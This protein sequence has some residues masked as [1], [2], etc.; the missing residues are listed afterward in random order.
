MKQQ[1]KKCCWTLWISVS[2]CIAVFRSGRRQPAIKAVP[3]LHRVAARLATAPRSPSHH[4]VNT[5]VEVVFSPGGGEDVACD[6]S[7]TFRSDQSTWRL[8]GCCVRCCVW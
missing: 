7:T 4:Q 6:S 3:Q 1:D 2:H 5:A 8:T